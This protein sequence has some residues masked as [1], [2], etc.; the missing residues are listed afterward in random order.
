MLMET[1]FAL[2]ELPIDP[3]EERRHLSDPRAGGYAAF[4][5]WVR[6]HDD[7]RAVVG[8]DYQAYPELALR[9]G[10]RVIAEAHERFDILRARCV[11][12]HGELAIGDLSVWVGVSAAHRDA[13]FAACRYVIDQVKDRLPIWK[14]EHYTEGTSVWINCQRI[15]E[16]MHQ[17]G[18]THDQAIAR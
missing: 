17:G 14:R 13:A 8:L 12:R 11:H 15:G 18:G 6:D 10:E 4:E 5:G 9:E 7:G 1:R 16:P 3:A 2:T